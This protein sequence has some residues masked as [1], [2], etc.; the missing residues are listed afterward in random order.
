MK[1]FTFSPIRKG[2]PPVWGSAAQPEG[3]VLPQYG[4]VRRSRRGL[5]S[6]SMGECGAAGGGLFPALGGGDRLRWGGLSASFIILG[7]SC[8]VQVFLLFRIYQITS[9]ALRALPLLRGNY[10]PQ[11]LRADSPLGGSTVEDR[12]GGCSPPM[13]ECGAKRT[14]GVCHP[15]RMLT[16]VRIQVYQCVWRSAR[17]L[18]Y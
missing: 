13:G 5:F 14:K 12:E 17:P 18:F 10:S 11:L 2:S 16:S 1:N 9:P 8:S 7:S 3:V 4:G 15:E 6:P